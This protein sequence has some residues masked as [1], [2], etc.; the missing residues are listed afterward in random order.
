M[1]NVFAAGVV[2]VLGV[3]VR[4]PDDSPPDFPT[5]AI[6]CFLFSPT[7]IS[8]ATCPVYLIF[9]SSSHIIS[10][11]LCLISLSFSLISLFPCPPVRFCINMYE[12][13]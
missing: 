12:V 10:L 5:E 4:A 7:K 1:C 6:E 8:A 3:R 9:S 13:D 11:H 2:V